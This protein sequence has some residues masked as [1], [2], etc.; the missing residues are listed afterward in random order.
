MLSSISSDFSLDSQV[1]DVPYDF[2]SPGGSFPYHKLPLSVVENLHKKEKYVEKDVS[3]LVF[4]QSFSHLFYFEDMLRST[5]QFLGN[6]TFGSAYMAAMDNGVQL[7]QKI[8]CSQKRS[9]DNRWRSLEMP[10]T[11]M[12]VH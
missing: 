12:C 4:V 3:D 9:L 5:A 8:E 6:R 11:K 7:C 1:L 10:G 2:S